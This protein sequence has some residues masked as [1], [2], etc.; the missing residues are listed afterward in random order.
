MAREPDRTGPDNESAR[1][2]AEMADNAAAT[3]RTGERLA[4]RKWPRVLALFAAI[5]VPLYA[6][7]ALAEDVWEHESFPWDQPVLLYLHSFA[8]PRLDRV[9][10]FVTNLG[11]GYGTIPASLLLVVWLVYRRRRRDAVFA[12]VA[13]GGVAIIETLLKLLFHR[14]RPHLWAGVVTETDYGFPSGH[15]TVNTAFAVT[16]AMLAWR[17]RWRWPVLAFAAAWVATIDLTRLY[18]GVHYPSDVLAGTTGA[19]AFVAGLARILPRDHP[20][21]EAEAARADAPAAPARR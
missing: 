17:T 16:L 9:V 13:I 10:V 2:G 19:L 21:P 4:A 18:L 6:F 12:T 7:G 20:D 8:S 14:V 5:A 11:M 1:S 15:A 3:V